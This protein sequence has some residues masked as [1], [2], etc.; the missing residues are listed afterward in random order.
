M[1]KCRFFVFAAIVILLGPTG[2][3]T[4]PH[5]V[6]LPAPVVFGKPASL[7]FV[8][9]NTTATLPDLQGETTQLQDSIL[10]GLRETGLFANV[11]VL[12][13]NQVQSGGI[14]V[15]AAIKQITKV[16]DKAR[17][18][19]GG[20]AGKAEVVVQVSVS[21]LATGKRIEIF[22]VEGHTGAF[23]KAGTTG[24]AVQKAASGVVSEIVRLNAQT[25]QNALDSLY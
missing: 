21:D 5:P 13:T 11:E 22:D 18:W 1:M 17:L 20:L 23:A 15:F 2:C 9:V 16:S 7:D 4:S 14:E 25:A 24:E 10:S 6:A 12:N 8:L 19:Y 3:A